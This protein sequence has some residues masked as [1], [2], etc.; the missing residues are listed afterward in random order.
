[1]NIHAPSEEIRER[2]KC[3]EFVGVPFERVA[4]DGKRKKYMRAKHRTLGLTM[5]YCFED[6]FAWFPERAF[7]Q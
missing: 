6:D 2:F 7:D 5:F 1:M 4:F 3:L